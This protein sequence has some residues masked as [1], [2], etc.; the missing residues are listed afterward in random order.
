[1]NHAPVLVPVDGGSIAVNC[2]H[3]RGDRPCGHGHQG[4]CAPDCRDFSAFGTR[5]LIIKLAALG[6]VIRTTAIL[7]GLHETLGRCQVTWVT[8]PE[9]VRMLAGNPLIDRLLPLDAESLAHL[10]HEQF[11]LCICLDKEPAPA[12]L[13]MRVRARQ[14]RGIGLTPYGTAIPLNPECEP[15]FRLGL[16]DELKFRRNPHSYAELIYAAIGLKYSGQRY[17]L[18]PSAAARQAARRVLERAGLAEEPPLLGLNTGAGGVFANKTWP[19]EKFLQ[20]ARVLRS[21]EDVRVVLLGGP[22]ERELNRELAAHA[23]VI[24][25]G[26]DHDEPTF[27]ALVGQCGALVTGDTM[28]L[29][30]A[31]ALEVPVIAL[32][33]PTCPQ[34]IDLFGKGEKL[35]TPLACS[36]CYRRSCDLSPNCMDT[37]GLERVVSAIDRWMPRAARNPSTALSAPSRTETLRVPLPVLEVMS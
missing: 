15:Y 1:M 26:C 16:D 18:H 28:A 13:A 27:A 3:F 35:I 32:F 37:I 12:G 5:V 22:R 31:V 21:R 17:S 10:E 4:L 7:P 11:D 33:G 24:D 8:R 30:A 23:D 9:G 36:P 14:R 2:R 19:P 20:L 34:E 29:H 6:D 25:L